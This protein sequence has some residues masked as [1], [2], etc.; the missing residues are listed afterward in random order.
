MEEPPQRGNLEV[1]NNDGSDGGNSVIEGAI[2]I[3]I[4]EEEGDGGV[5]KE[6]GRGGTSSEGGGGSDP[7]SSK[8]GR[9]VLVQEK[10]EKFSRSH[11]TGHSIVRTREEDEDD[12]EEEEE[13]RFTLRVP[14]H[15]RLKLIR[16]HHHWTR[17][18][19]TY[20][21]LARGGHHQGNCAGFGE[22]S[23]SAGCS[24]CAAGDIIIKR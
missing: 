17:S 14:E 16:G 7:H 23:S 15:V 18:C 1:S 12:E 19:T 21:E 4:R 9:R 10:I 24:V 20:G 11:S 13:D 8:C 5:D 2:S 22:V 3:D 6:E